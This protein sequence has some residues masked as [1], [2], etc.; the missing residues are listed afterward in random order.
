MSR[1]FNIKK[2]PV[3]LCSTFFPRRTRQSLLWIL[4]HAMQS[5]GCIK[6]H[7]LLIYNIKLI[8]FDPL[9]SAHSWT[10]GAF[11][12]PRSR[13][14]NEVCIFSELGTSFPTY[15]ISSTRLQMLVRGSE[16][17]KNPPQ[18]NGWIKSWTLHHWCLY[19]LHKQTNYT[20]NRLINTVK[21]WQ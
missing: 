4:W 12:Y 8:F 21:Q 1:A 13:C 5:R 19:I 15:L 11:F 6:Y 16:W 20:P 14:R 2:Y 3:G 9:H 17:E 7:L 18:V 10:I